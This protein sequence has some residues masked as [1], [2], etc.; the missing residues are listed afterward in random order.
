MGE[1][2]DVSGESITPPR[3]TSPH[4]VPPV[5]GTG[6]A[7]GPAPSPSPSRVPVRAVRAVNAVHA[8]NAVEAMGLPSLRFAREHSTRKLRATSLL[9]YRL[10]TATA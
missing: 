9:S 3:G 7:G 10:A 2:R 8:V 6:R 1:E 5:L 4:Y